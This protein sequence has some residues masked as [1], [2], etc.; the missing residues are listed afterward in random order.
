MYR[1]FSPFNLPIEEREKK[2]C[3]DSIKLRTILFDIIVVTSQVE[4]VCLV[5]LKL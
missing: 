3:K 1:V 4:H 5:W 2:I